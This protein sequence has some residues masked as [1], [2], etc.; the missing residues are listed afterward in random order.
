MAFA[1]KTGLELLTSNY[2]PVSNL[3]FLSK[4]LEKVVLEQFTVHCNELK[5]MPDYQ[6]AYRRNYSCKP[7]LLKW[8]MTFSGVWRDKKF[9]Q[10]V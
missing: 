8:L 1:K 5:M 7:H 3:V 2:R 10:C 6:L 4:A 9:V